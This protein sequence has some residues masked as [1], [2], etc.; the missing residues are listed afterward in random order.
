MSSLLISKNYNAVLSVG[1]QL[2]PRKR[3]Y[4]PET[5]FFTTTA[6]RSSD[7]RFLI[8]CLTRGLICFGHNEWTK[9]KW[10]PKKCIARV[11]IR[12][13][14]RRPI[15][16]WEKHIKSKNELRAEISGLKWTGAVAVVLEAVT[17]VAKFTWINESRY[18]CKYSI[19]HKTWCCV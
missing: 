3:R 14:R 10:L 9:E 5:E 16:K 6:A 8:S 17:M 2:Y 13:A 15:Y 1:S 4:F 19:Y 12:K 7:P 18:V 11:T